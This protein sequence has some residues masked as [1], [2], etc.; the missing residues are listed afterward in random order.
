[1]LV[2]AAGLLCFAYAFMVKR[3]FFEVITLWF[4]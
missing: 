4:I 2:L 3:C 1:M